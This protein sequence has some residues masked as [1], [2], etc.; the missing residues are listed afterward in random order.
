MSSTEG[1]WSSNNSANEMEQPPELLQFVEVKS[2]R[3]N[4]LLTRNGFEYAFEKN[5]ATVDHVEYWRCPKAS[6]SL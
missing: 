6:F 3:G 1:E 5:S 2:T 4:S